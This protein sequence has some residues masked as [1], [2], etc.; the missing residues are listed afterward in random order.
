[1][2]TN[3]I[4]TSP[5]IGPRTLF[6]LKDNLGAIGLRLTMDEMNLLENASSWSKQ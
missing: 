2:L 5:I 1:M 3:P 4:I 6:Q